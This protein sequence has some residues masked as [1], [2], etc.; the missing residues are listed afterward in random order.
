[1]H[2]ADTRKYG[3]EGTRMQ[4]SQIRVGLLVTC[5]EPVEAYGSGYPKEHPVCVFKPGDIG[6]IASTEVPYVIT[7]EGTFACV[8]FYQT[9][10]I[11]NLHHWQE[12]GEA[13]WRAGVDYP[14]LRELTPQELEAHP[15][16]SL[17]VEICEPCAENKAR[18]YQFTD[19]KV[20]EAPPS[21]VVIR[22]LTSDF[23]V[24]DLLAGDTE[25]ERHDQELVHS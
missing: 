2:D 6:I 17:T 3:K 11:R 18:P 9:G 7:R 12:N 8:G 15:Y 21:Q 5:R 1:M 4:K 25:G 22:L 16:H 19:A 24:A 10:N 23:T 20:S 13:P 14:N